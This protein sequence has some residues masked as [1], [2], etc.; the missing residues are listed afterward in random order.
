[1]STDLFESKGIK[2]Y[3]K[4]MIDESFDN[5]VRGEM[6][7]HCLPDRTFVLLNMWRTLSGVKSGREFIQ[8]LNDKEEYI[9]KKTSY[10]DSLAS[11]RRLDILTQST[12]ALNK[13][14]KKIAKENNVDYL[15]DFPELSNRIVIAGDGHSIEHASHS[16][17][18]KSGRM[19]AESSIHLLDLHTGIGEFLTTVSGD[20]SHAHEMP[21]LRK[22]LTTWLDKQPAQEEA[23]IIIYDRAAVD[24]LHWTKM[25]IKGKKGV[26]VIT[27]TKTNMVFPLN[28][29]KLF[30]KSL[31]VNEGVIDFKLVGQDN[32]I[33]MNKITYRNPEDGEIYEFI[34][35]VD[36]LE[37]GLIAWLYFLRWKI[38]KRFDTFKNKMNQ[39]KGWATGKNA[40][41]TQA[42]SCNCAHNFMQILQILLSTKIDDNDNFKVNKKRIKQLEKRKEVAEEKGRKLHPFLFFKTHIYQLTHQFIRAV[43]NLFSSTKTI[44]ELIPAFERRLKFYL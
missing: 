30:D 44:A 22:S 8:S 3:L 32:A 38:E 25:M 29:N 5:W 20:G 6:N 26:R 1:M 24:K 27:R 15:K 34:T 11:S 7:C 37:P 19:A 36:D 42:R 17:K 14:M 18:S 21:A 31:S 28:A 16:K 12:D 10:F 13:E 35:T 39:K 2:D 40:Q 23:P 4:Y 9:L 33:A 41:E 43:R